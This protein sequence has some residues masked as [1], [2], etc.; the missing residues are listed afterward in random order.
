MAVFPMFYL[1]VIALLAFIAVAV[2]LRNN[3]TARNG[4]VAAAALAVGV[5]ALGWILARHDGLAVGHGS[6]EFGVHAAAYGMSKRWVVFVLLAASVAALAFA[7]SAI[8]VGV[9]ATG[10]LVI[11]LAYAATSTHVSAPEMIAERGVQELTMPAPSKPR[12]SS[13]RKKSSSKTKESKSSPVVSTPVQPRAEL[14]ARP[15]PPEPPDDEAVATAAAVP[16]SAPVAVQPRVETPSATPSKPAKTTPPA[17]E[18]PSKPIPL[19]AEEGDVKPENRPAWVDSKGDFAA[20]GTYYA[21]IHTTPKLNLRDAL[22]EVEPRMRTETQEFVNLFIPQRGYYRW[23]R[24]LPWDTIVRRAEKERY[25]ETL[26]SRYAD[27][28]TVVVHVRMA[29]TP[30]LQQEIQGMIQNMLLQQRTGLLVLIAGFVLSA[31]GIIYS[32]L[33]LDTATKG[34][35]TWRLRFLA[36][37]LLCGTFAGLCGIIDEFHL[38]DAF[39]TID[40]HPVAQAQSDRLR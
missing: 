26:H 34:Y 20:D 7:R 23:N 22:R 28:D 10:L 33:R 15:T 13:G 24:W 18:S 31:I 12:G 32:Y 2:A 9:V 38:D 5:L 35:Y 39:D 3:P 36:V 21:V 40:W 11:V 14:S 6:G 8:W 4:G 29:F 37:A 30:Q 19:A 27:A 17:S 1:I 25:V 16:E